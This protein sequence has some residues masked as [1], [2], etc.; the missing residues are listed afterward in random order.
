MSQAALDFPFPTPPEAGAVTEVALGI[1]WIRMKLPF[2]L[3]HINLWALDDGDGWVLVD[4]GVGNDET[5]DT[6]Q[7]LFAGPLAAKPVTGLI[8]THFHPDHM[9]LAGPLTEKWGVR[10]QATVGEWTFGRMLMLDQ[11][12]DYV[13]NQVEHY[14]RCAYDDDM[15]A[16]IRERAGTYRSRIRPLPTAITAIRHGSELTIGGRTWRV[17]EGGGH[18]PEHACLWCED[19][20]VLIS[21]DQILPKISPIIG[22]WPQEPDATPLGDFLAALERLKQLPADALVL[23]SHNLPFTGL[24]ARADQLQAHH[25]DRLDLTL[26]ACSAQGV[27]AR[28]VL[29]VLFKRPLDAQQTSFAIGESLSH[30]HHLMEQGAIRRNDRGDGVWIYAKA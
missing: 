8:C 10:M 11:G 28:D 14:R 15:L 3:D 24:H 27:T 1:W 19:A 30:L 22:V 23:P 21:G 4:T 25:Q 29:K 13:E 26:E 18:S 5:W 17:L 20:N 16:G 7:A 9:G 12:P 2:A 6:W